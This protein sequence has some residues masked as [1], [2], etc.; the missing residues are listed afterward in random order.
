[1]LAATGGPTTAEL[2]QLDYRRRP[3]PLFPLDE[4]AR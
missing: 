1:V 4:R 2:S 3:R